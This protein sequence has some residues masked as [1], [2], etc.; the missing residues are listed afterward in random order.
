M[1][2]DCLRRFLPKI[3]PLINPEYEIDISNLKICDYGNIVLD[4][5][6]NPNPTLDEYAN[7]LT[8]KIL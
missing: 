1:Q 6:K 7:K 4:L 2:K 3:G 5:K 8:S